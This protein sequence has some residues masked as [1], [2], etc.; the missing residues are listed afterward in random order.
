[1][2]GLVFSKPK[3]D[4]A[5]ADTTPKRSWWAEAPRDAWKC[6]YQ[7]ERINRLM[8]Q[9]KIEQPTAKREVP[10][11]E[12]RWKQKQPEGYAVVEVEQGTSAMED[13]E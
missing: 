8:L 9:R 1:M 10:D 6:I 12:K 7:W 13:D 3:H 11:W 4:R 2:I 5:F